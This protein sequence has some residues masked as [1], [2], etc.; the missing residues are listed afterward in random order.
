MQ[1]TKLGMQEKRTT[2]KD[3]G[4]LIIYQSV[5]LDLNMVNLLPT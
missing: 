1:S 3:F 2:L 5:K 4:L